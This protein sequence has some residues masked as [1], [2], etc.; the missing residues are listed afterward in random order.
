MSETKLV[1]LIID[2]HR[3]YFE[4]IVEYLKDYK[5]TKNRPI[6]N[7]VLAFEVSKKTGKKH[8]HCTFETATPI[9]TIRRHFK[10]YFKDKLNSVANVKN[11]S[12]V[13]LYTVKD[14]DV[15]SHTY[16]QSQVD[17]WKAESYKKPESPKKEARNFYSSMEKH[18]LKDPEVKFDKRS[19]GIAV[20]KYYHSKCRC[21]PFDR[22]L[23]QYIESIYYAY[24]NRVSPSEG[25]KELHLIIDRI[26]F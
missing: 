13:F 16:E 23:K 9:T 6:K 24:I 5:G 12:T 10:E 25:D 18:I 15:V 19:I 2:E 4:H 8:F 20:L 1:H 21:F 17:S 11:P 7:Y 26:L 22:Q 3:E 14:G